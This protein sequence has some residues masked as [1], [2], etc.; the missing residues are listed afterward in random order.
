MG[1]NYSTS[2]WC[3]MSFQI[4]TTIKKLFFHSTPQNKNNSDNL[5]CNGYH[6]VSILFIQVYLLNVWPAPS[7]LFTTALEGRCYNYPYLYSI[8]HEKYE[9]QEGSVIF[10]PKITQQMCVELEF[11][12]NFMWLKSLYF[13][14]GAK[15][16]RTSLSY[17]NLH[18]KS[19]LNWTEMVYC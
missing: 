2:R 10:F 17:G 19:T 12:N 5:N 6:L 7:P 15:L 11:R 3:R 4:K 8:S 14:F 9:T 18:G 13:R 16:C 1:T